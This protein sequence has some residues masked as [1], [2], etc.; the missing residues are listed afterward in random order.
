MG[1]RDRPDPSQGA[2]RLVL[3]IS[4]AITERSLA[5]ATDLELVG[6]VCERVVAAG[7]PLCRMLIGVDTLHPLVGGRVFTWR[8]GEGVSLSEYA[9]E[10]SQPE[11]EPWVNSPFFLLLSG[12]GESPYRHRMAGGPYPYPILA[13]LAE[14]GV[15]DYIACVHRLGEAVRMGQFDCVYSSWGTDAADGFT[16]EAVALIDAIGPFVAAALVTETTRQIAR[17]LVATYLGADAGERVLRGAIARGVAEPIRA[18]VWLSDLRGF[19]RMVDEL[20]AAVVLPLLN[21][22]ADPQVAA[23]HA[24]GGTV[25]KFMGDGLLAIFPVGEGAAEAGRRALAAATAALAAIAEVSA[26]RAAAGLP[27]TGAYLALHVGEVFYGNIGGKERLDFTVIGAA[28]NEAARMSSLCG[29]LGQDILVSEAFAAATP[30]LR[31]CLVA[32]G[33]H[34]LR[35]VAQAQALFGVPVTRGAAGEEAAAMTSGSWFGRGDDG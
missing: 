25:L 29:A 14:V 22:Y 21:D 6:W 19:T 34:T 12:A 15:T 13:E 24:H 30:E 8:R 7:V 4:R 5:G 27:V 26:R 23:I 1:V 33:R 28:V 20:G 16:E 3:E 18:V 17:T 31:R 11:A 9:L 2:L 35:G 32:L 10:D